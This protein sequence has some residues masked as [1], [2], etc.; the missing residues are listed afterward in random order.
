MDGT[1]RDKEV[2]YKNQLKLKAKRKLKR[3]SGINNK[4]RYRIHKRNQ[5]RLEWKA[6]EIFCEKRLNV[7]EEYRR[8]N[9]CANFI[10]CDKEYLNV[11]VGQYQYFGP[12]AH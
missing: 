3:K 6:A 10:N 11:V 12:A 8:L 9:G 2:H 4:T 5:A 1:E 7:K